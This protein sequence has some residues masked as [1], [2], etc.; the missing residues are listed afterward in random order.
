MARALKKMQENSNLS[1]SFW[2]TQLLYLVHRL[3][4]RKYVTSLEHYTSE[5]VVNSSPE[6]QR[7]H[8]PTRWP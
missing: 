8:S 2:V 7:S 4:F 1:V 3:A 6:I 5:F